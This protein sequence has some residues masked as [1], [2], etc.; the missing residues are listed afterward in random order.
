MV[1]IS[2]KCIWQEKANRKLND[3]VKLSL[4]QKEISSPYKE[5]LASKL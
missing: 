2:V 4:Q 3:A 5:D 1:D